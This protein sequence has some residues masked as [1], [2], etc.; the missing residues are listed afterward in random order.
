[1]YRILT[2]NKNVEGI[3][4]LLGNLGLDFTFYYG[5]GSWHGR[6]EHSLLIE[7]DRASERVAEKAARLIKRSNSQQAVL[8]QEVPARSRYI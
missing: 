2:E 7:L 3:R 6:N 4:S 8:L 5:D 1:M